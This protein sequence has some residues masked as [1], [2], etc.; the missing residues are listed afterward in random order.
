MRIAALLL[1]LLLAG[2]DQ[3]QSDAEKAV[4]EISPLEQAAIDA[5]VIPD[6]RN[7][8]LSGAYE[9]RS[10]LGTD[11]F[12][13]VGN[14]EKGYQIGMIAVFGPA[15]QCEGL[16]EAERDGENVRITLNSEKKCSFTARFD[17]VELKLPG[18]LPD[19]CASYC[20]RRAGFEGVSFYR[21]GEG[22]AVAR[23]TGGRNFENLC[24]GG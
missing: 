9:R 3:G 16:G 6:V 2:C 19:G 18:D 1:A 7:V 20:S 13:A 22:D 14:D 17:G 8:T 10:D 21:I 4:A 15:T 24:P 11:S 23:S 5:G 12:C